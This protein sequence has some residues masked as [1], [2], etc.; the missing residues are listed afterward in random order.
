MQL[1]NVYFIFYNKNE[2]E[3]NAFFTAAASPQSVT[4]TK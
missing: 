3:I 4:L 2:S 1:I